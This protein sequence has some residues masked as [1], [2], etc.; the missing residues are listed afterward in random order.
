MALM[1]ALIL[2]NIKTEKFADR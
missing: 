2:N 1:S